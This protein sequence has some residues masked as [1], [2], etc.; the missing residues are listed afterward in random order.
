[1]RYS[2]D[3]EKYTSQCYYDS[4][5]DN[6]EKFRSGKHLLVTTQNHHRCKCF[7]A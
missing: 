1:M 2:K 4:F 3:I 5:S 6:F 7:N